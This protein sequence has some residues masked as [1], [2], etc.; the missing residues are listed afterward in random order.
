M[1]QYTSGDKSCLQQLATY[2]TILKQ[3]YERAKVDKKQIK[4]QVR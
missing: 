2:A 1:K 3:E 4:E